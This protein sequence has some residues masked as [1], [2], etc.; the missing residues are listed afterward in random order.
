MG[1]CEPSETYQRMFKCWV[2][3]DFAFKDRTE[4]ENIYL[5]IHQE[6]K[7]ESR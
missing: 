1:P 2:G 5:R 7:K 6:K 4:L 3:Y